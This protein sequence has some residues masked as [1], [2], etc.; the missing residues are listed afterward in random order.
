MSIVKEQFIIL[1]PLS[2]LPAGGFIKTLLL[3]GTDG[4]VESAVM[5][6]SWLES[7]QRSGKTVTALHIYFTV[8]HPWTEWELLSELSQ[9]YKHK[10]DFS[11][12]SL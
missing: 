6:R 9:R 4:R 8:R 3:V 5:D 1:K 12:F 2:D 7:R 10:N 11:M